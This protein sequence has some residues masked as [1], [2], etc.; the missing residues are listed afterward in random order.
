MVMSY[1]NI[2]FYLLRK[3]DITVPKRPITAKPVM[4]N[5]TGNRPWEAIGAST[6]IVGLDKGGG[7]VKVGKRVGGT[8]TRN[9]AASVGSMVAVTRGV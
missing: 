3:K 9:C 5:P 1:N 8:S 4:I 2:F 7:S 6:G